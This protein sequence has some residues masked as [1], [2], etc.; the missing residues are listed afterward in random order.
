MNL[1]H[2][3]NLILQT[4]HRAFA[5]PRTAVRACTLAIGLLCGVGRRTITRAL[6]F[7]AKEQTDWSADYR[8]F[9]RSP[10]Q[11]KD[12]FN[13]IMTQAIAQHAD[14]GPLIM[15]WD[16]TVVRRQGRH[17]PNT[18]WRRDPMSPPFQVNLIWGQRYLMAALV[19]P[20]YREDSKSSPRTLPVR[21]A[22]CPGVR[23]PGRKADAAQLQIY[24]EEKKKRRLSVCFIEQVRAMRQ[25]LDDQGLA[26]RILLCA[27]DGSYCNQ[28]VF[29]ATLERTH[30]LA[31]VRRD[32]K[33]CFPAAEKGRV[34]SRQTWTPLSVYEDK[35]RPWSKAR[36]FFGGQWRDLRYK[37]VPQVLWR[38][39]GKT[40]RLRLI[41]LA[42]T[43]YRVSKH[44]PTDYR[45]KSFLLTDDLTSPVAVL[46]QAYLDRYQIEFNHRDAKTVLGV[47]QAQ[48]WSEKSTPRVPEFIVAAYSALLLA[49]LAAYGPRRT[50]DYRVLPK[51]RRKANRPS[52]QDLLTL[53]RQQLAQDK[54]TPFSDNQMIRTAAA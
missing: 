16:D 21:F 10:W 38:K 54:T 52:C 17:V 53:L 35:G 27:V 47:G 40:K 31:R 44:G 28:T 4:W 25:S 13:P 14:S 51:W 39:A 19:L 49:G 3:F 9:S 34:Y 41:V 37:D 29:K 26:G 20:L 48:V 46:I 24:R 43:P 23:K 42:P 5:Q 7:L 30:I 2:H 12:L 8:V 33:L 32:A 15:A 36:C 6:G 1:L 18:A 22:E 50:N 45:Q 11:G